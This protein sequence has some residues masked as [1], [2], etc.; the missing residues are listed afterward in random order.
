MELKFLS[1]ASGSS[2]NCYYLG[3][4]EFGILF[5]AGVNMRSIKKILKEKGIGLE[6]IMA[7][8]ITHDHA[9]HILAVG[10]LGDKYGIPVYATK[11]VHEGIEKSKFLAEQLGTSKRII[12]KEV[13]VYIKDFKITAFDVPHDASD[14]VGYLVDYKNH[15]WVLATDVGTI[16]DKVGGYIRVANHLVVESNYDREMLTKGKYP[17]FLKDRISNGHGHLSNLETAAFIAAN[18][19]LHL[20]NIWLCHLSHENNH[21][22]LAAK[23]VEMEMGRYGIRIGKDVNLNVLKRTMP[24]EM[25]V[26]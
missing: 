14:C 16:T 19:D 13:A 22:D 23:T 5:D 12:E 1:L 6:K 18:F 20:K 25:F 24:S 15:K 4:D 17:K 8:F 21:P 7:V 10:S 26:L 2:G 3:T 9:D 11:L